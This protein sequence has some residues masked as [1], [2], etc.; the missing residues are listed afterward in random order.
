MLREALALSSQTD[1]SSATLGSSRSPIWS[2][3]PPSWASG[4]TRNDGGRSRLAGSPAAPPR[5]DLRR[6]RRRRRS[7]CAQPARRP[8]GGRAPARERPAAAPMLRAGPWLNADIALR[9]ADISLD[10]G[11]VAGA[12]EHAQVADDALQGYPDAGTLP[13]RLQRL[14]SGSGEEGLRAHSGRAPAD[15]FPADASLAPGDRRSSS[16]LTPDRQDSCRVDLPQ[17]RRQ[18][19]SEAVEIIEQAGLESPDAKIT[20]PGPGLDSLR[21]LESPLATG[22]RNQ[23]LDQCRAG[24]GS[25]VNAT[26]IHG[27]GPL[28]QSR[29]DGARSRDDYPHDPRR[30]R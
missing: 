1:P 29:A 9:C 28:T 4:E 22:R 2:S 16:P 12:L 27:R 5:H 20:I 10:L 8:H 30:K 25:S 26:P 23:R 11:D 24:T 15:R 7:A 13:A 19:R 17:A 3:R 6:H 14:E 18:G 21:D